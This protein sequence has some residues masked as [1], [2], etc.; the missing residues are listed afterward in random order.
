MPDIRPYINYN[1]NFFTP[2][3]LEDAKKIILGHGVI[4]SKHR[5]EVETEWTYQLFR[6]K[7]FLNKDSI[8]LDWGCGIGRLS[9]MMI[10]RFDCTV[11]GVD[12][13]QK[14]LELSVDYVNRD[15]FIPMSVN[16]FKRN[17]HFNFTNAISV[18]TLQHSP[19][20]DEDLDIIKNFLIPGGGFFIFEENQPSIPIKE[21]EE[22]IWFILTNTYHDIILS[23]FN[24]IDHGLFPKEL[25]IPENN[26]SWWGFLEN[27]TT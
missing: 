9:K 8:V 4:E 20:V 26:T 5:W 19:F 13:D 15:K 3:D 17:N 16:D 7:N 10:D 14:M 24:L 25:N 11:V 1:P 27:K 2:R 6:S 22:S 21:N 18:W 23:K 12:I